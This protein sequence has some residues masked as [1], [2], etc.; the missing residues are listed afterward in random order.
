MAELQQLDEMRR[1]TR[2]KS[3]RASERRDL[4]QEARSSALVRAEAAEARAIERSPLCYEAAEAR[5]G[6]FHSPSALAEA[7]NRARAAEALGAAQ[8]DRMRAYVTAT[9]LQVPP[10]HDLARRPRL[11]ATRERPPVNSDRGNSRQIIRRFLRQ[12]ASRYTSAHCV[13]QVAL[14]ARRAQDGFIRVYYNAERSVGERT[15]RASSQ[16]TSFA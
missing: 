2:V 8:E 9:E 1:D 7:R 10:L 3:E 11:E 13:R 4:P 16:G 15:G 12:R 5:G 14:R 6:K